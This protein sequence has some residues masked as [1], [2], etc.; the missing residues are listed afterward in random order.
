MRNGANKLVICSC[1]IWAFQGRMCRLCEFLCVLSHES[2]E[3][4]LIPFYWISVRQSV[5]FGRLVIPTKLS[6]RVHMR[7][8]RLVNP[9]Y[10][11]SLPLSLPLYVVRVLDSSTSAYQVMGLALPKKRS[12]IEQY[13]YPALEFKLSCEIA[14][15]LFV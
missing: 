9:L 5:L 13:L 15:S 4:T 10:F 7:P 6:I 2:L 8:A 1:V 11:C 14:R 12:S 3:A